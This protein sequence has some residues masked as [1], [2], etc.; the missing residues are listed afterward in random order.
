M[1]LF[2]Y[3]AQATPLGIVGAVVSG[4]TLL[5]Q[6]AMEAEAREEADPLRWIGNSSLWGQ[7]FAYT[8]AQP[9]R[10]KLMKSVQP[11]P[12]VTADPRSAK[13]VSG[14]ERK[15]IKKVLEAEG[16][17]IIENGFSF[18]ASVSVGPGGDF[19]VT[20][21]SNPPER[22][23]MTVHP[24]YVPSYGTLM[25]DATI[26][27]TGLTSKTVGVQY[28][29]HFVETSGDFR[30][31][32]KKKGESV[33]L[34]DG[35]T[36]TDHAVENGW[37]TAQSEP[38]KGDRR[39]AA[40]SVSVKSGHK[41]SGDIGPKET[42]DGE[43]LNQEGPVA[44]QDQTGASRYTG[45]ADHPLPALWVQKPNFQDVLESGQFRVT[46]NVYFAPLQPFQ[47]DPDIPA[48]PEKARNRFLSQQEISEY[49]YG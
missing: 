43:S 27:G 3:L 29:V 13:L 48:S 41:T 26:A 1:A 45:G 42:T 31:C 17:D 22:I 28:A 8:G 30:Y 10:V 47:P 39:A 20:D 36:L 40:L 18:P 19:D 6:S 23:V 4:A 32:V 7:D 37:T 16:K 38:I 5:W 49:T 11:D 12:A 14:R 2:A 44:R 9:A 21:A 46:G 33:K 34:S 35:K 15:P 24:T 25:V